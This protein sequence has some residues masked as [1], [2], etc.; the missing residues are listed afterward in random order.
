MGRAYE[1]KAT[2]VGRHCSS[3]PEKKSK[4]E[5]T[6]CRDMFIVMANDAHPRFA[7]RA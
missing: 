1:I 4:H 3:G 7:D 6:L 2:L 5:R